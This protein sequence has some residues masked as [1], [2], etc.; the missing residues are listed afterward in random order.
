WVIQC[1]GRAHR[2]ASGRDRPVAL[3][4][5]VVAPGVG[6]FFPGE[7]EIRVRSARGKGQPIYATGAAGRYE[8]PYTHECTRAKGRSGNRTAA[9]SHLRADEFSLSAR[10]GN[11]CGYA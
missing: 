7:G 6:E 10:I 9:T 2:N 5:F 11:C 1:G 3:S 8:T 4:P